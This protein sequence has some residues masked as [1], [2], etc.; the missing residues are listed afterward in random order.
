MQAG[1]QRPRERGTKGPRYQQMEEGPRDEGSVRQMEGGNDRRR[2]GYGFMDECLYV[3]TCAC[4]RS[5][6][7]M[8]AQKLL[9][10]LQ[11][12]CIIHNDFFRWTYC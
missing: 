9:D 2:E 12:S 6:G 10:D 4:M 11:G 8:R 5:C 1:K 3:R 7:W